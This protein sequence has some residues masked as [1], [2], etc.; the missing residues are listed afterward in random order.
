[1]FETHPYQSPQ[2]CLDSYADLWVVQEGITMID[3][4]ASTPSL[5]LAMVH[6]LVPGLA[7]ADDTGIDDPTDAH[8]TEP[9]TPIR[10]L[11]PKET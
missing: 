5:P 9:T 2:L 6:F 4:P 10:E 3:A 8:L 11:H 1:M 7:E